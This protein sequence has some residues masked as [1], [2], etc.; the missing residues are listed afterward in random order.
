MSTL[1]QIKQLGGDLAYLSLVYHICHILKHFNTLICRIEAWNYQNV[2]NIWLL[3]ITLVSRL[4]VMKNARLTRQTF[5]SWGTMM[6]AEF[7]VLPMCCQTHLC[8]IYAIFHL[9]SH[10]IDTIIGNE[11]VLSFLF[12][13][14]AVYLSLSISDLWLTIIRNLFN[15]LSGK[16]KGTDRC[17][18]YDIKA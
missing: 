6:I 12:H 10:P 2:C 4:T 16:V 9:T 8:I 14:G 15:T 5:P 1:G 13:I 3:R 17:F 18:Q 7:Y 11:K